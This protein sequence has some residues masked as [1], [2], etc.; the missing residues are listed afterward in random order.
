M[1]AQTGVAGKPNSFF[2]TPSLKSW[3]EDWGLSGP[4][5][6]TNPDYARRYLQAALQEGENG[7]GRFGLRLMQENLQDMLA[8]LRRAN[9]QD[10]PAPQVIDEAFGTTLYIHLSRTDKVAQAISRVKAIQT[11]LWHRN[12]DGS[13]LERLS[14]P[15]EPIYDF[16]QI[17]GF[18]R[19]YQRDDAVWQD[20]FTR[21]QIAPLQVTYENLAINPAR[22]VAE[23][24]EKLGRDPGLAEGLAPDVAR[25]SDKISEEW[26]RMYR[27]QAVT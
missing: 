16:G 14:A 25:L 20:W 26:T 15:Q 3:A 23:I 2:R 21:H 17:D 5:D 10:G 22:Y 7:T 6:V 13:E 8:L 18:V 1:L 19:D 12:A 11:G 24:L 4:H 27:A 9:L